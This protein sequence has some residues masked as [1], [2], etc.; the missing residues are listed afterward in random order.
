VATKN[1]VGR[2]AY[3]IT[4]DSKMLD[5]SLK[6]SQD[7]VAKF[8]KFVMS[9]LGI[10]GAIIAVRSLI[11]IGKDLIAA[12]GVQEQAE[13]RLAAAIR[14][15]GGDVDDLMTQYKDFASEVQ[16]ATTVGDEQTLGLI[17]IGE[18]LGIARG[19]MEEATKG[20]IGLSK[21]FG[22][23]MNTAMRGIALAYEGQ[24]TQLSRYIP[25]LRTAGSE[26]ERQAVLQEAMA[27]GFAIARAEAETGTGAMLQLQNAIG[28]LK[29]QGGA[30]L[31]DFLAPSIRGLTEFVTRTTAAIAES[32]RLKKVAEELAEGK[33]VAAV[34]EI[35]LLESQIAALELRRNRR[36]EDTA[37]LDRQIAGYRVQIGTL[38][39]VARLEAIGAEAEKQGNK[40][41][42]ASAERQA[43]AEK[44][45]AA[46]LA[47][48]TGYIEDNRSAYSKLAAQLAYFESFTWAEDQ[49][50]QLGLQAQA[51]KLLKAELEALR[52]TQEDGFAAHIEGI[53][54]QVEQERGAIE[55]LNKFRLAELARQAQAN[56][57]AKAEELQAEKDQAA[58][59]EQ[60]RQQLADFMVSIW[61]Q[62]DAAFQAKLRGE[63]TA[64]DL[65]YRTELENFEGTEEEKKALEEKYERER[66]QLEY[67]AATTSWKL[68]L[69][70]AIAAAARAV[71]NALAMQPFIPVGLAAAV[72]AGI[73]G[74]VQIAAITNAKPVPAFATGA[75]FVVPPGYPDDSYPM[76]VESGEHVVVE[77]R[78]GGRE[79]IINNMMYLDGRELAQ[80]TTRA[81]ADARILVNARAIIK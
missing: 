18:S 17:Q 11:R 62:L 47:A 15:T 39:A 38:A 58:A 55:N 72:L 81:I 22:I 28:D 19:K 34:D 63:L 59:I 44:R 1:I 67:E 36:E 33:R 2:L 74:A 13:N 20:A 68:Q 46:G 70:G 76:R 61:G 66:A 14:A 45:Y 32:R 50:Y 48:M 42:Q 21:A 27:N 23:D 51:V 54:A 29:E 71:L 80:W 4:G 35:A 77:P 75:D 8:S 7:R 60:V 41:K 10:G 52:G 43:E 37:A 73:M 79:I 9:A 5:T 26:A 69:V 12:Y 31:V 56:A 6:G 16:A 57:D 25:A 24:Y 49:T 40:E 65:R 30:A 78:G 53:N 64:L 3:L